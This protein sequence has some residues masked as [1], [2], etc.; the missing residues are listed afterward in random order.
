MLSVLLSIQSL[1]NSKPYHNEPG[2][3][4]VYHSIKFFF[5]FLIYLIILLKERKT[6]DADLYNLMIVH[7]T[8]KVSICE[9]LERENVYPECIKEKMKKVFLQN[10]DYFTCVC[11]NN[12]HLDD[13]RITV[14]NFL[15]I[16]KFILFD[17][18]NFFFSLGLLIL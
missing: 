7:E 16:L 10:F 3:E 2:F 4:K 18:I 6:G 9:N 5:V 11:K 8:L 13:T 12:Q 17:F 1:L 15:S 14:D